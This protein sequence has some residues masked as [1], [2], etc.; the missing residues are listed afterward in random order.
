MKKIVRKSHKKEVAYKLSKKVTQTKMGEGGYFSPPVQIG[1]T[2]SSLGGP[3]QPPSGV[4]SVD[5][6]QV[7]L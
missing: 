4:L 2:L 1:L 3:N 5:F 6:Y 7:H